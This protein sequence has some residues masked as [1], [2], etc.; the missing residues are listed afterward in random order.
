MGA[1]AFSKGKIVGE[2]FICHIGDEMFPM[3]S[4][5]CTVASTNP[6]MHT[7]PQPTV[8]SRPLPYQRPQSEDHWVKKLHY[9]Y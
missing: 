5:F 3:Q 7:A 1:G 2:I 8:L 6:G 4:V 9:N